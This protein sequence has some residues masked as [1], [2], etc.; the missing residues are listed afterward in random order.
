MTDNKE[1]LP[2]FYSDSSGRS[3]NVWW[4]EKDTNPDSPQSIVTL[5]KKAGLKE[6]Y[7]VSNRFYDMISAWKLCEENELQLIFGLELWICNNPEE[8]TDASIINESKVII[9]MKNGDGYKDLIKLYSKIFT[10]IQ[11]KYYHYRGSWS[12]LKEF[13]TDNLLLTIPFF[14]SFLHKNTLIHES[15]IIPDFPVNPIFLEE[16]NSNIPFAPLIKEALINFTKNN[17]EIVKTKTIYYPDYTDS[18]AWIVFRS[19][20]ERSSFNKP[21]LDYCCSDSFCLSDYMEVSK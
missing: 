6:V 21:Q 11:N 16:I 12:I 9:F 4:S 2:I 8:H 13:W 17:Y 20:K 7:F 5:A 3:I 18:T 15:A 19:I 14:D 1:I 10:N